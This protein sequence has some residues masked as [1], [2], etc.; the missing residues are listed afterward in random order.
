[1]PEQRAAAAIQMGNIG[2]STRVMP[3][4]RSSMSRGLGLRPEIDRLGRQTD[5]DLL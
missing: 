1:M 3:A 4:I 5:I 2:R